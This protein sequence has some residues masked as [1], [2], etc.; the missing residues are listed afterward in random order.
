MPIKSH[1]SVP[2]KPQNKREHKSVQ[3]CETVVKALEGT[4]NLEAALKDGS[5]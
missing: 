3:R 4:G 1:G 2:E 5:K